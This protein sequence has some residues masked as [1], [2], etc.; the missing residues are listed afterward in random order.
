MQF[1]V[2]DNG[3]NCI[4][5]I[6]LMNK[7]FVPCMAHTLH[8]AVGKG[9]AA[10]IDSVLTKCSKVAEFFHRSAA[11]KYCLE[12]K[13]RSLG[14]PI[15][16]LIIKCDI[17]WNSVFNMLQRIVVQQQAVVATL[18]QLNRRDMFPEADMVTVESLL[19]V[20]KPFKE[21]TEDFSSE[22]GVTLS[23]LLPTL[24]SLQS[25]LQ[26][27][28]D[29]E[30]VISNIKHAMRESLDTRYTEDDTLNFL[31]ISCFL[32]PRLKVFRKYTLEFHSYV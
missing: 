13:Q 26:E 23:L 19:K 30:A 17:R 22:K 9:L 15:E 21:V 16:K 7:V 27:E 10:G 20:L 25:Q 24:I 12:E 28:E 1:V 8:L 5:A 11:A 18:L 3:A 31:G 2:A 14:L 29:E 6:R 4:K 32:D